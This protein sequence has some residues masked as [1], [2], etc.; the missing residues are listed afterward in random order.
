MS[1]EYVES[2]VRQIYGK[3]QLPPETVNLADKLRIVKHSSYSHLEWNLACVY[4]AIKSTYCLPLT[5]RNFLRIVKVPVDVK[6]FRR[7]YRRV[8]KIVESQPKTCYMKPHMYI[9]YICKT[10]GVSNRV[11]G[12]ALRL[13]EDVSESFRLYGP[14]FSG[15]TPAYVAAA[16]V[17]LT[18]VE[19]G[20]KITQEQIANSLCANVNSLNIKDTIVRLLSIRKYAKWLPNAVKYFEWRDSL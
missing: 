7:Y 3:L 15:K 18:C 8:L 12:L 16:L 1:A 5:Y 14:I 19:M 11:R 4:A 17:Y 9:E 2:L 20:C 13:A 10:L 6:C